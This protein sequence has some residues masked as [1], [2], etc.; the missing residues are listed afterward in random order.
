MSENQYEP[1]FMSDG[2]HE[3]EHEPVGAAKDLSDR[4]KQSAQQPEQQRR[5]QAVRPWSDFTRFFRRRSYEAEF[6]ASAAPR[7]RRPPRER[8]RMSTCS[9]A[10]CAPSPI[11]PSPSSVGTPSAA[12]KLPSDPPPALPSPSSRPRAAATADALREQ[13]DNCGGAFHRRPLE[14]ACN[15]KTRPRPDRLQPAESPTRTAVGRRSRR[16][17]DVDHRP[18]L[19]GHDVGPG[20]ARHEP[21]V[22]ADPA[23]QVLQ[24]LDRRNL[25]GQ[26]VDG[27][28][29]LAGIEPRVGRHAVHR[30]LELA[31]PL[32]RGLQ[33][34]ARQRRLEHEDLRRVARFVLDRRRA[35]SR[36]RFP[37]RSS[38]TS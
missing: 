10:A 17:P 20:A 29:A 1:K 16:R 22:D 37:R 19:L 26:L 27:A 25:F 5:F 33:R 9:C 31:A 4:E 6:K 11:A 34:A 13:L 3:P 35:T 38:T 28:G 23:R 14:P 32:A 12:V 30:E 36:C 18:C 7:E 21:D 15:G 24:P 2:E 8:R